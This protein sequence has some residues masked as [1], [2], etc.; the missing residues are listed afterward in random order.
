MHAWLRVT[1][2]PF[3]ATAILDALACLLLAYAASGRTVT[4]LDVGGVLL[5]AATSLLLYLAG[6]A[7]NDWADRARDA[8]IAPGRPIPSGAL[9]PTAVAVFVVIASAG[10]LALG[11]GPLGDRLWVAASLACAIAYNAGAKRALVPGAL[12]MAGTRFANAGIVAGPLVLAGD[13]PI[14][15]LAGPLSLGLYSAAITVLSTTEEVERPA[16]IWIARGM[17]A[18]SFLGAAVAAWFAAGLPTLGIFLAFGVTSSV[19]FGRTP[20]AGPAKRQVLEML[21]AF[22]LLE[23]VVAS[24]VE[25]GSFA[26]QAIALVTAFFFIWFSQRLLRA[27]APRTPEQPEPVPAADALPMEEGE[28]DPTV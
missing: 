19:A 6:M 23:F 5:L 17:T 15:V 2:V 28:N 11:G 26:G 21:L 18:A 22:Y 3:A 12:M 9:S 1:R 7:G 24:A 16:R 27:L 14:W 10:A 4:G 13:A 8:V 25:R 20:R